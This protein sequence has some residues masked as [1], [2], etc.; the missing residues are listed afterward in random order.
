MKARVSKLNPASGAARGSSPLG[1]SSRRDRGLEPSLRALRTKVASLFVI[2]PGDPRRPEFPGKL[3]LLVDLA[4]IV[5]G[6]PV[7]DCT[8]LA[9]SVVARFAEVNSHLDARFGVLM[10]GLGEAIPAPS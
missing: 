2:R 10:R 3:W 8:A 5:G 6:D 4:E 1:D 9:F 7:A